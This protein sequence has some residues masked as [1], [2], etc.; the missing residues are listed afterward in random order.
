MK[1]GMSRIGKNAEGQL[2]EIGA[3]FGVGDSGVTQ[4]S[5]RILEK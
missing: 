2:A 5:R 3:L 1:R 4:A